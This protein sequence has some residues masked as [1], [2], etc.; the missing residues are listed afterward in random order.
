MPWLTQQGTERETS[1]VVLISS[2]EN[3]AYLLNVEEAEVVWQYRNKPNVTG[4]E[5]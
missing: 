2:V 3:R 1:G 5:L 4:K